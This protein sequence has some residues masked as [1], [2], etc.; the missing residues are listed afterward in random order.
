VA[1]LLPLIPDVAHIFQIEEPSTIP[2]LENP[3]SQEERQK[4]VLTQFLRVFAQRKTIVMFVDDL[5]WSSKADLQLLAGLVREFAP[6]TAATRPDL[7][8]SSPI[9]LICAYRDN[10]VGPDHPVRVIFE[11]KV[12]SDTIEVRPLRLQDTQR[13]VSDTLHRSIEDCSPLSKIIYGR[14]RGNP[15]FTQRVISLIID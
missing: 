3:I 11:D 5:Q 9:L 12:I 4:R 6:S 2:D 1:V 14:C 10:M 8:L 13:L 15:F 7:T